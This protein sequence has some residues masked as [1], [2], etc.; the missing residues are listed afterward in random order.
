MWWRGKKVAMQN[1]FGY[2]NQDVEPMFIR[3]TK[4]V[5]GKYMV[6]FRR[7]II[8]LLHIHFTCAK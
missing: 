4:N 1:K 8:D 7:M 5:R 2:Q 3:N 6:I